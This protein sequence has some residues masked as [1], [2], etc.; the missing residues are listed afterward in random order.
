M[1]HPG[2]RRLPTGVASVNPVDRDRGLRLVGAVTSAVAA[3]SLVGIGATTALAAGQTRHQDALKAAR[4][5]PAGGAGAAAVGSV[6][7]AGDSAPTPR[8]TSS[9]RKPAK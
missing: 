1:K 9:K 4:A 8:T 5:A 2:G 3:V 6:S 7:A